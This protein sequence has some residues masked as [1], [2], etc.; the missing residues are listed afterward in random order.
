LIEKQDSDDEIDLVKLATTLWAGRRSLFVTAMCSVALASVY[1]NIVDRKYTVSLVLTPVQEAA[2]PSQ[3]S[4]LGSLASFAGIEIPSGSGSDFSSF[5][6]LLESREVADRVLAD[7]AL[8]RSLFEQE[9]DAQSN[10]WRRPEGTILSYILSPLK[11]LM[12]GN[13]KDTYVPPDA[14]RLAEMVSE[15]ISASIDK[16]SD[17]LSIETE[18]ASPLIARQ[19]VDRLVKETDELLRQR[20]IEKG[21]SALDFYKEQLAR[22]QS[23]EHREALAQLI[24]QE[25][26]KLM[27]AT[28][29]RG[30]VAETLRGPDVSLRP[31]SPKSILVLGLSMILG[32]FAGAAIVLTRS[33]LSGRASA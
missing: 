32:L 23:G 21:T 3:M 10:Q 9:W 16:Q 25:E 29:S 30:Y 22:A 1:L 26:Q 18:S 14:S 8:V 2:K 20:F 5:P 33:T 4:G 7:E 24:V 6:L 27:L 17:L 28:R 15:E 11:V 12:T 19:F 13:P 31:T